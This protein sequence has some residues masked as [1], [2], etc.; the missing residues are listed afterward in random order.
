MFFKKDEVSKILEDF[1]NY[2]YK[3]K[4]FLQFMKGLRSLYEKSI[5]EVMKPM[6]DVIVVSE[7]DSLEE[8]VERF[9]KYRY[10]K[11]PV[12]SYEGDK[13]VG[14]AH[15]KDVIMY[16]DRIKN[17]TVKEISRKPVYLPHSMSCMKALRILQKNRMSMG[18]VVD[19]FGNV[20]GIITIEDLLE[21]VAGEI[22]EE[23]DVE[24]F[25]YEVLED[26]WVRLS[27]KLSVSE[28]EEILGVSLGEVESSTIGGYL[29][30]KLGRIPEKGE[31]I[32]IP[33]L[34]FF[35]EEV[36]PQRVKT[37]RV[38]KVGYEVY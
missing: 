30:E 22:Y 24:E 25:R 28:V 23:H 33:P 7:D 8:M 3:D 29:I 27:A 16:L 12:I 37:I 14:I 13:I 32:D 26:G 10:S 31:E 9:V 20:I 4:E 19:E 17:L 21:E 6:V 18:L 35:V 5:E 1:K 36:E 11:Y 38:K 34:K 2:A 15:I